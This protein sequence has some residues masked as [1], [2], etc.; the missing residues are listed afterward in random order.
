MKTTALICSVFSLMLATSNS[1][2]S[3]ETTPTPAKV[4]PAQ[5]DGTII[6]LNKKDRS[7]TVDINGK[8]LTIS[9]TRQLKLSR[10][11]QPAKFDELAPGQP[12]TITF[13]ETA[14]GQIEVASLTIASSPNSLESAGPK[15]KSS[16][17]RNVP[18]LPPQAPFTSP[19]NP[20]NN[21]GGPGVSPHN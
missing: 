16:V 6:A 9:V 4:V 14:D 18:I 2:W 19:P 13:I 8:L 20:A 10:N 3:A 21:G 1:G 5:L 11:G 7:V 12:V 15:A 17:N